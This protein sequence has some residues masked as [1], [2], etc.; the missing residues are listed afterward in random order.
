VLQVFVSPNP[1]SEAA[2]ISFSTAKQANIKLYITDALG[3]Q[4]ATLFDGIATPGMMQTVRFE[5]S[6]LAAG[7]YTGVFIID[8]QERYTQKL[9][10]IK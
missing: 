10:I 5:S 2:S 6:A 8:G 4:I 1:F 9:V 7:I 3:K